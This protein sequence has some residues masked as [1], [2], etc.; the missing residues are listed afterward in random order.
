MALNVWGEPIAACSFAP[1]TGFFRDGCCNTSQHDIGQHTVCAQ[2][3]EAFLTFSFS[4]GND[5]V[6][7]RPEVGFSGLR[8]GD[9]WCLC[10]LRWLEARDQ[11]VA[12]PVKLAATNQSV[13]AHIPLA[14]LEAYALDSAI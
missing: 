4:I 7:P 6:T 5:L 3:S 11:G 1:L 12:P 9:F 10:A 14:E 8:P 13:L 2:V